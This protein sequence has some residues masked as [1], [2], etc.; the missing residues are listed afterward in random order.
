VKCRSTWLIVSLAACLFVTFSPEKTSAQQFYDSFSKMLSVTSTLQTNLYN[1]IIRANSGSFGRVSNAPQITQQEIANLCR[2]FVCAGPKPSIMGDQSSSPAYSQAPSNTKPAAPRVYPI[3]ATDF[4]PAGGRIVP[5]EI[6]RSSQGTAEEKQLLRIL[7]EQSLDT[8]EK[9]G[10]KNNVANAFALL[11]SVSMQIILSRDLTDAE[12]KQ[13]ISGFNTS[14]ASSPQFAA[15]PA[16]DKQVMYETAAIAG[17]M[18]AFLHAQ[19]KLHG[20][21]KM[22]S[23]ARMMAKAVLISLFGIRIE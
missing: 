11:T 3:T 8:L 10:R 12:E 19:G 18:M 17:G 21:A 6:S 2:P 1:D 22:Q 4:R 15:M 16:R 20:D 7:S 23:D 13:L 9:E 14:L 5:D